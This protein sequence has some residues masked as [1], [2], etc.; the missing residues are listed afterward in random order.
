MRKTRDLFQETG[1]VKFH[2]NSPCKIGT[3]MDRKGKDLTKTEKI[4]RWQEHTEELY[5]KRS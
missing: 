5:K 2:K 4:K 3:I 1:D